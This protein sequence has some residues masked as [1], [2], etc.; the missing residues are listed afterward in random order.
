MKAL[1]PG[2]WPVIDL[3]AGPGGLGE[4]FSRHKDSQGRNAFSIRLSIEC[5]PD[6]HQ[7]LELRSFFRQFPAGDVPEDYYEHLRG[8]KTREELFQK[9]S[10]AS[11]NAKQEAWHERLGRKGLQASQ[12]DDRIR[13]ALA[14]RKNWVLIGGPP[15]Q[16]YSVIGRVRNSVIDGYTAEKDKR[17]FLYREYLRIIARHWPTVFVMENVRGLLSSRISGQLIFEKMVADLR[18]PA[19]VFDSKSRF[20][21]YT[22]VPLEVPQ[23]GRGKYD[24][25]SFVVRAE[26]HGVPQARHRV[27]LIG[28]R[29]DVAGKAPTLNEKITT[30]TVRQVI[31]G[32]PRLR[33]VL[34]GEDSEDDWVDAVSELT[35]PWKRALLSGVDRKVRAEMRR[36]T[37]NMRSPRFGRG[38]EFLADAA[39]SVDAVGLKTWIQ[40]SR[41]GGVLNHES[42]RHMRSDLHR[43]LFVSSFGK[44]HGRSPV[45][46]EFPKKLLPDHHSVK[47]ALDGGNFQDRF[48]VQ[49][50]NAPATTITSHIAK[51]GHY[52]IHYDPA[53]CRSLSVREAARIQTFPDNY[54]FCG[55][56]TSQYHQVGNAVPPY[57]AKQIAAAVYKV[58]G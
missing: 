45:L 41:I 39:A 49:I 1:S 47:V 13:T 48:R 16:A 44:V 8:V 57:L 17:H 40:D 15:C 9:W 43:Y 21:G 3:F 22:V 26:N 28:I 4:G 27:I 52:Y 31:G 25:E 5:D 55:I 56:R 53:Q 29:N 46:A 14:G 10:Q 32:L 30:A 50:S 33:S 19:S 54:L 11:R 38:S 24:A 37:E 34:T 35:K 7:T 51:D 36:A 12:I 23:N 18:D 58:I 2:V 20:T 42:R 6:A